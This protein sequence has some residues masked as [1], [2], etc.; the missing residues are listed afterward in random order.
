MVVVTYTLGS[1]P[2]SVA[3]R[4]A[5]EADG[6]AGIGLLPCLEQLATLDLQLADD[7]LVFEEHAGLFTVLDDD[8]LRVVAECLQ[9]GWIVP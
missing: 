4:P 7:L 8:L 2:F 5:Q 1:E 3:Y 9:P 6:L